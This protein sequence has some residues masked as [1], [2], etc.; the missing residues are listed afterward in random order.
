MGQKNIAS[1]FYSNLYDRKS[2]KDSENKSWT[3]GFV[4]G[5]Y[6]HIFQINYTGSLN[7]YI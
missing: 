3:Q 4:V 7:K 2:V 5:V 6:I 1:Y